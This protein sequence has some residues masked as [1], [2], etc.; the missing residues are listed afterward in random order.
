M[1]HAVLGW[2]GAGSYQNVMKECLK[3]LI[4]SFES[5][6]YLEQSSLFFYWFYYTA[7]PLQVRISHKCKL[8]FHNLP[9]AQMHIMC[10]KAFRH[11]HKLTKNALAYTHPCLACSPT[12]TRKYYVCACRKSQWRKNE[13]LAKVPSYQGV[14]SRGTS[15]I[16]P[17]GAVT[18][19]YIKYT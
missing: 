3:Q 6:G 16:L 12:C 8:Y 2:V 1:S 14:L 10:K 18:R 13:N 5:L 15:G 7:R 11:K 19:A 4:S 17:F 9:W